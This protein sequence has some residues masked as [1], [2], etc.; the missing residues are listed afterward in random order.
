MAITVTTSSRP[1]LSCENAQVG[2]HGVEGLVARRPPQDRRRV[3]GRHQRATFQLPAPARASRDPEGRAEQCLRRGGAQ[4]A[5]DAGRTVASSP[6]SHGRQA[7]T[8]VT[9]GVLWMRRLPSRS[10]R[11][12]LT[13]LVT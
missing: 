1:L 7:R 4:G 2:D 8:W 6:S 13:A 9:A 3:N 12:C 11:K 10:N 5:E